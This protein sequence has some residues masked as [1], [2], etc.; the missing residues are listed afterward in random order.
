MLSKVHIK[1]IDELQYS[2]EE[3]EQIYKQQIEEATPIVKDL[4]TTEQFE[5]ISRILFMSDSEDNEP[6]ECPT[7]DLEV[8]LEE[9]SCPC[10]LIE[11]QQ[12]PKIEESQELASEMIEEVSCSI[13]EEKEIEEVEKVEEVESEELGCTNC[14]NPPVCN[15]DPIAVCDSCEVEVDEA[16]DQSCQCNYC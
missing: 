9:Q 15:V 8:V 3:F 2:E 4:S 13:D 16:N 12:E 11:I 10:E 7:C 6:V 1:K 5:R 14:Q